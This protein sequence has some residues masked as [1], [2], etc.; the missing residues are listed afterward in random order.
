M[1]LIAKKHATCSPACI[2]IKWVVCVLLLIV[3]VAALVGV[4]ET[5]F[6]SLSPMRVQFGSTSGSLSIMA[7]ALAVTCWGKKMAACMSK[8][9][10]CS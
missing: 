1:A 4:Y 5:H 8:C 2:G 7:F 6:L 9:D 10:V 3:S